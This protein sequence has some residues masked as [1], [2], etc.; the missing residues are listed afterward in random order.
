MN[1]LTSHVELKE[2]IGLMFKNLDMFFE[3]VQHLMKMLSIHLVERYGFCV[4][5]DK[6]IHSSSRSIECPQ[7]WYPLHL[8]MFFNKEETPSNYFIISV[9]IRPMIGSGNNPCPPLSVPVII[10]GRL[11][12]CTNLDALKW[13]NKD[14]FYNTSESE[15]NAIR[16]SLNDKDVP[17]GIQVENVAVLDRSDKYNFERGYFYREE[18]FQS[19]DVVNMLADAISCLDHIEKIKPL[20]NRI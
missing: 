2:N 1:E 3:D 17:E 12:Q 18:L 16:I 7:E 13:I 15:I 19:N 9:I 20:Q 5:P 10:F 4:P 6:V 8:T 14:S 11:Y